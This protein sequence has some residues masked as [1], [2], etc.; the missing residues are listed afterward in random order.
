MIRRINKIAQLKQFTMRT[1][2]EKNIKQIEALVTI[3][4]RPGDF[5]SS[6]RSSFEI[7]RSYLTLNSSQWRSVH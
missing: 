5:N 1:M 7:E 3:A 2:I 6:C 4:Q